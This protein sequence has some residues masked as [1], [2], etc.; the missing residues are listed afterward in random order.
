MAS[1]RE[2]LL[3]YAPVPLHWREGVLCL[4]DQACNGLRLWASHFDRLILLIPESDR[5]APA[6]WVPLSRVGP[7]LERIEIVKLPEVWRPD[8]FIRAMPRALPLIREAIGRADWLGFSIGGLFGDWGTV[9]AWQ[10]HRMG[11]PFYIWT[12]RVESEVIRRTLHT[13]PW[14]RRLKARL[15]LPFMVRVERAL[16]RRAALGLFHGRETFETYAP[17]SRNAHLVHDIHVN[18]DDR[19]SE[20]AVADKIRAAQSG[21]LRIVYAGRAEAMKGVQDWIAV[22]ESLAARGVDFTATWLGDGPE[23]PAMKAKVVAGP[24]R[25]RVA[26]PGFLADRQALLAALREAHLLLFCHLTPESPR[27][28]IEALVSACPMVGY[29]SAFPEDL[30]SR[31][32]GGALVPVGATAA[33]SETV[34]T[35]DRDRAV[36]ALKIASAAQDGEGFDDE[37]VFAHRAEV[38][39]THLPRARVL[40]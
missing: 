8:R 4:E 36:L 14:R 38:I 31:H 1:T 24:L 16:I 28:L 20:T 35:L 7:A 6:S 17:F 26:F 29:G 12:D 5:P 21:P 25:D 19:I 22:L 9:A 11:K 39:R 15:E 30:I 18:R 33:L 40:A 23:L 3:I 10:A 2:T 32:G 37:S 34:A 13:L 27:I